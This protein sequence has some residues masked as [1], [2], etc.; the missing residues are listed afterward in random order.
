ML[1]NFW[2]FLQ[3]KKKVLYN[4]NLDFDDVL[5]KPRFS[6]FDLN[7][8]DLST[9]IG[10]IKLE[11]P[12]IVSP[13]DT[14][15]DYDMAL[16][17][18]KIGGLGIIHRN[19]S[20]KKQAESVKK[21][22]ASGVMI[23][24]SIGIVDYEERTR[25]LVRA[26]VD[27]ICLDYAIGHSKKALDILK[28]LHTKYP[29]IEFMSGSIAS[30]D[31]IYDYLKYGIN[32]F[33]YGMGAGSI[34]ISRSISGVGYPQISAILDTKKIKDEKYVVADGGIRT[35]A[36]IVKALSVG[37]NAVMVGSVLSGTDK[38]PGKIV[39]QNGNKFKKYRGMGSLESMK[40]GS[41]DRYNQSDTV[42]YA[43][44]VVKMVPY[45]GSIRDVLDNLVYGIRTGMLKAGSRTIEDLQKKSTV[46]I[47]SSNTKK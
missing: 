21:V 4:K 6:D 37:A 32:I 40:K 34:C 23:G 5:L 38:S 24:A 31:A 39:K 46:L 3:R 35:S 41:G 29:N 20:I 10:K 13:M 7:E 44:G 2:K 27:L 9:K 12:I 15:C 45:K 8:I 42:K 19:Q 33:R 25:E 36:D 17:V 26:G 1:F 28:V 43:E 47:V 30:S 14:V 22:K 11:V 18:G 16:E